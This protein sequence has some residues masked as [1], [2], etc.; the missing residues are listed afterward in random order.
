VVPA[1]TV[2]DVYTRAPITVRPEDD[3]A[4]ALDLMSAKGFKSLPVVDDQHRVVGI[5]SRSDVVRGVG[6]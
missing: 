5:V 1:R 4:S 6:S 3:A 2:E